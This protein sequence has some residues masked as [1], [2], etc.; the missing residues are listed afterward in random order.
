MNVG[1]FLVKPIPIGRQMRES[2]RGSITGEIVSI[3]PLDRSARKTRKTR[4]TRRIK[5]GKGTRRR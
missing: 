4:K 1:R 3:V 5:K 2:M